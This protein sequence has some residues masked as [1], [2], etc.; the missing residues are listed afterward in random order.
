MK[1]R[2]NRGNLR[3]RA[4]DDD[5]AAAEADDDKTAVV[6]KAKQQRGEPLAFSTKKEGPQDVAVTFAS[7]A[8]ALAARD[9][10]AT[11]TLETETEFDR[12]SRAQRERLLAVSAAGP[13]AADGKYRGANAYVDY[14]QGLRREG[15]TV[16][17][18]K[19]SGAYGPLR[20]NVFV[21]TTA[22]FD[23]QPDIC[24][25]YKE[26]G[27]CSYGDSCKFMHDRG[28]YKS[29][30]ELE[31]EWEAEQKRRQ[32]A[33][34]KGWGPEDEE[35]PDGEAE[36]GPEDDL[37][38]ACYIC[39][40]PW[41]ECKS[42]PVVTKCRHYFCESCALKRNTKNG[43][44]AACEQPTQGIFN[45]ATDILKKVKKAKEAAPKEAA[46]AEEDA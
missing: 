42:D 27:F 26:T 8:A 34:A 46:E 38:F 4:T 15:L 43:K 41:Q 9:E 14:K 40:K 24:K 32:E 20:G 33:L 31:A 45:I 13:A 36:G 21:R 39:R 17:S 44:C 1:Q 25:D 23:Y 10:S 11:K 6:R 28:D 18:E 3:K 22:R 16:G 2:K 35:Q 29:G 7:T 12:D 19:G 37:P 5:A 30:W